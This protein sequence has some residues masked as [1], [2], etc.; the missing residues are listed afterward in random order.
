M[1]RADVFVSV[2]AALH[3]DGDIVLEFI[4]EA[5]DVLKREYENYELVLVDDGSTDETV[6]KVSGALERHECIRL[7][8]LSRRFGRESALSAGLDSVI[9]DYIVVIE[10]DRDPLELIPGIVER[11]REGVGVVFGVREDRRGDPLL[12]RLASKMFYWYFTRVLRIGLTPN[13]TDYRVLSRQALN[14]MI[15]MKDSLRYLRT[16]SLYIGYGS[17]SF[18][19]SFKHR[20]ARP[21][22]KSLSESVRI[23]MSMIVAS[24]T[25]PLRAVS[26]LALL[27]S[28]VSIVIAAYVLVVRLVVENVTPGWATQSLHRSVMFF[29]LFLILAV[30]CEYVGRLLG[31]VRDRPLYHVVEERNSSVMIADEDRRNVV[32]DSQERSG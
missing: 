17:E 10:P 28:F 1:A 18:T 26:L 14:A 24:S 15:R 3:N 8:V 5:L 11:A 2:V 31:E 20:R 9:G 12:K 7:I 16:F 27:M 19:Y 29:F 30:L 4:E 25:Q 23:G 6:A 21:R 32:T 13:S 22:Q